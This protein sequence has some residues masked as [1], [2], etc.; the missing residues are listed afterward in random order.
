MNW[1]LYDRDLRHESVKHV[2]ITTS[3]EWE[4]KVIYQFLISINQIFWA[5]VESFTT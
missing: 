1:S 2:E 3:H 5:S 4:L